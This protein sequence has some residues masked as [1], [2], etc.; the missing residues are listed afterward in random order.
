MHM[1]LARPTP[2]R[3]PA[4]HPPW[5]RSGSSG[6]RNFVRRTSETWRPKGPS[7]W[8]NAT[9]WSPDGRYLA[10]LEWADVYGYGSESNQPLP[11][12]FLGLAAVLAVSLV[13]LVIAVYVFKRV[14]PA[15]AGF[16]N[17]LGAVLPSKW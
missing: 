2:P 8:Y 17:P 6:R 15:I 4:S 7:T 13:L 11:P 1:G 10:A 12:D 5:P 3:P 14:E 16:H 9:A